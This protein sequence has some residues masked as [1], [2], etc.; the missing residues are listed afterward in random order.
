MMGHKIR[1]LRKQN[2]LTQQQVADVLGV[3]RSTYCNYESGA[4]S[5]KSDVI[6]QLID[7][8]G[9][10]WDAFYKK[11]SEEL[12]NDEEYYEGQTDTTY[13][14]QLSKKE[15]DLIVSFRRM[16]KTQKKSVE[17]FVEDKL[18]ESK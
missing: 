1:I 13:L 11:V 9:V 12:L 14:S 5:I 4:R 7:F 16:N 2:G 6:E 17:T 15:K 3:S 18:K 8:Y 10:S